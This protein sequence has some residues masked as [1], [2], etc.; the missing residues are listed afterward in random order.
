MIHQKEVEAAETASNHENQLPE[1]NFGHIKGSTEESTPRYYGGQP[2]QTKKLSKFAK[3]IIWECAKDTQYKN[4][5]QV[6]CEVDTFCK[7]K[8]YT[9]E[10]V[11]SFLRYCKKKLTHEQL[12][13]K[14]KSA[15]VNNHTQNDPYVTNYLPNRTTTQPKK[16]PT[17]TNE[18]FR[19]LSS[20]EGIF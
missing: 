3:Q 12:K 20:S 2:A 4:V 6:W 10:Q 19:V 16:P 11:G 18:E 1:G 14:L 17:K 13:E 7:P 9:P 15:H 5:V 8:K